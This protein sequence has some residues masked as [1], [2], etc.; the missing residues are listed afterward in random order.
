MA[1]KLRKFKS[2]CSYL[3]LKI[4]LLLLILKKAACFTN[5]IGSSLNISVTI[6]VQFFVK[7]YPYLDLKN[8]ETEKRVIYFVFDRPEFFMI[9]LKDCKIY[10]KD[11]FRNY[12][13]LSVH[14]YTYLNMLK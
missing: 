3:T 12:I 14:T 8:Q 2:R 7:L 9:S 10:K 11:H 4:K 6:A 1:I 5:N 13:A